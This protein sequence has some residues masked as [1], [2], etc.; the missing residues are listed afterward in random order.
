MAQVMI[1]SV[2]GS[3]EREYGSSNGREIECFTDTSIASGE[4]VE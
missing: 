1:P 3:E 2:V 4:R